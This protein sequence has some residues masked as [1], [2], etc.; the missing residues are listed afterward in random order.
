MSEEQEEATRMIT[1]LRNEVAEL[2]TEI[3]E[4]YAKLTELQTEGPSS[5]LD[6]LRTEL[7]DYASELQLEMEDQ[8][9]ELQELREMI[10]ATIMANVKYPWDEARIITLE[11]D[12]E[13]LADE[14]ER[15]HKGD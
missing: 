4:E 12:V 1:E 6:E 7:D 13:A 2:R 9:A 5:K 15:L 8:A 11:K 3:Q 14:V 10:T